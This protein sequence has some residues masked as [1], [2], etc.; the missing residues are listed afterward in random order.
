MNMNGNSPEKKSFALSHNKDAALLMELLL[1]MFGGALAAYLHFRLRIPLNIPGHHGL[2]FMAIFTLIRLESKLR[3]AATMATLGVGILLLFPGM[4]AG[5]PL[6][7]LGYLLPGIAL[8]LFYQQSKNR[9]NLLFVAALVAGISYMSIPLSRLLVNLF[10]GYPNIAF[11]KIGAIY[12]I[13]SFL[14]FGMLGGG[15]G[16]SLSNVKSALNKNKESN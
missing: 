11:V 5:N 1:L 9:M 7:S 12:T 16:F 4:G 15:L 3:Y 8:D 13:L 2:E 10:T 6:H 14:L